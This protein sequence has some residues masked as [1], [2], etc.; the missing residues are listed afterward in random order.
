MTFTIKYA[1][2]LNRIRAS[3]EA[4]ER[5]QER[6]NSMAKKF[7]GTIALSV[8]FVAGGLYLAWGELNRP[9]MVIDQYGNCRYIDTVHGPRDCGWEI[10]LGP[11]YKRVKR[12]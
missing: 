2:I 11:T 3:G 9:I 12:R 10:G 7:F 1:T 6:G 5:S 8:I 4:L